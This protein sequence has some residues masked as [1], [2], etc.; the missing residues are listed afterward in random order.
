MNTVLVP[1]DFS[2]ATEPV[3]KTARALAQA[4]ASRIV[5]L[6][7][8]EPD[9]DFIGFEPGPITVRQ[10]VARDFKAEHQRL[11]E[12]KTAIAADGG[13]VL[14][15]HI[16]GATVVKIL[17]E[18]EQQGASWIVIGT[19]GHG[20]FYELLVGSVAQGVIK[21]A[22]CPVVVVPAQQGAH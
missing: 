22:S 6:H 9:P 17:Q 4:F 19:H 21:G 1:I 15:L 14:A 5:L 2:D 8:A 12:L 3:V 10:S 7:V 13:E 18:A 16:Q 20:A 11:D